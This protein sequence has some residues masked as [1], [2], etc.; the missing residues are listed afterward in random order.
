M[1]EKEVK[2]F[3]VACSDLV[4]EITT[5]IAS[6]R[7]L[8]IRSEEEQ[9]VSVPEGV[10]LDDQQAEVTENVKL[11]LRHLE[12]AASRIGAASMSFGTASSNPT[13]NSQNEV[14]V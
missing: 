1:D 2:T 10:T 7:G 12:D 13:D 4:G 8:R 14:S 6:A 5:L 9:P 11:A 3:D